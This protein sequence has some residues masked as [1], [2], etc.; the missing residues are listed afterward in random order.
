MAIKVKICGITTVEDAQILNKYLPEYAGF[1]FFEKSKRNLTYEKAEKLLSLLDEKI[2]PVAVV[3]SPDL[4][5]IDSLTKLGFEILQ[6]HGNLTAEIIDAW[7]GIIWQAV[8]IGGE[9]MP[10][11]IRDKKIAGYVVDGANYGGGE[12]FDWSKSRIHEAFDLLKQDDELRILAGGLNLQNLSIGIERFNPDVVD[13][14]SGVEGN[15]GK[16]EDK[17]KHFIEIAR[18]TIY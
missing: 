12:N 7:H 4:D 11:V 14:S 15:I 9:D 6:V 3:V 2:N 16:D 13:V 18:N 10:T 8:N 17:V 1:V 5:L